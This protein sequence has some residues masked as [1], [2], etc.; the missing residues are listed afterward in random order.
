MK[1][2]DRWMETYTDKL[3]EAMTRDAKEYGVPEAVTP[4]EYATHVAGRMRHA[5]ERGSYSKDGKAITA[6]C[7]H[8]GIK[9][10]YTAINAFLQGAA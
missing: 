7:K 5:F 10:T 4:A 3:R 9:H 2:L 1:N 6:T 8:F